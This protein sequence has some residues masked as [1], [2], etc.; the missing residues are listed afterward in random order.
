MKWK[1]SYMLLAAGLFVAAGVYAQDSGA[2]K[3]PEAQ[4]PQ[5]LIKFNGSQVLFA[6]NMPDCH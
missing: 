3:E 5:A 4:Q 2:A 6:E 1:W